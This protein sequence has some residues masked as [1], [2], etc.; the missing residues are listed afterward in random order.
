MLA[1]HAIAPAI[2]PSERKLFLEAVI[3][4]LRRCVGFPE[5]TSGAG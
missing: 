5:R 4:F 3:L 1:T 2:S